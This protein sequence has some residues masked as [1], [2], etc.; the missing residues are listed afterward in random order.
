[1]NTGMEY[2]INILLINF[3]K[4]RLAFD[5][6]NE[7]ERTGLKGKVAKQ[8]KAVRQVTDSKIKTRNKI[9][10]IK[11]DGLMKKR[12]TRSSTVTKQSQSKT[13]EGIFKIVY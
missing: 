9:G 5:N 3:H 10:G 11:L 13:I 8:T 4:N 12:G 6:D 7:M 2:W 1:M